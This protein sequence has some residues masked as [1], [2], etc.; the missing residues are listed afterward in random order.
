MYYKYKK[1][2]YIINIIFFFALTRYNFKGIVLQLILIMTVIVFF[3]KFLFLN[4][5]PVQLSLFKH[6]ITCNFQTCLLQELQ[7]LIY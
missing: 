3:N 5:F 2:S 4:F 7:L 1:I 6:P